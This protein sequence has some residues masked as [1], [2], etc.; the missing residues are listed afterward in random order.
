MYATERL[1]SSKH[2]AP[3]PLKLHEY[4]IKIITKILFL[5]QKENLFLKVF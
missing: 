5:K 1:K 4:I 3:K 2:P